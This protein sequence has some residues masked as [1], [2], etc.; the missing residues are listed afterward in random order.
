MIIVALTADGWLNCY[1]EIEIEMLRK[2]LDISA[3]TPYNLY[4][5]MWV[6]NF[7]AIKRKSQEPFP[8]FPQKGIYGGYAAAVPPIR[9]KGLPKG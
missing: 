4:L 6:V 8:K 7:V 5:V 2:L 9:K 1:C 3:F